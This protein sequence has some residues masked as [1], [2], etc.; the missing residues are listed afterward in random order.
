[1]KSGKL[2]NQIT[3]GDWNVTQV[4]G[5]DEKARTI[6]FL[7]VGKEAGNDPYFPMYYSVGFDGQNL[8]LL[9]PERADHE[10]TPSPDNRFFLDAFSTPIEPHQTVV[11]DARGE[12]VADVAREDITEAQS[13]RLDSAGADAGQGPRQSDRPL[14]LPLPPHQ[15][16]H[17]APLPHRQLRLSRPAD[18]LLRLRAFT[19]AHGDLQSLAEL[20]FIVVCIDGHGHA[21]PLQSL[22]RVL[23]ARPRRQHHPRP[24]RRHEAA[25]RT[26][27]VDRSRPRRHLGTLRRRQRHRRRHV[28]LP[29]LLQSR[30][31]RVRQ[32]RQPPLRRR[33]GREVDGSRSH[34]TRRQEQL[35]LAGQPERREVPQGPSAAR[36]RHRRRQRPAN[37]HPAS[38]STPSRR[39]TRTSTSSSSPT[40]TTATDPCPAT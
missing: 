21:L 36:A 8:A 38:S 27:P 20:G 6:F 25:R 40:P 24:G 16:L 12:I 3:S 34:R 22:P 26:L 1:M 2:K 5:V 33:L 15:L 23:R 17:R 30:H 19:A 28:P 18:R 11:R 37:Q 35:R 32:P 13:H 10:I 7:G 4:L 29:R 31:R 14:R 39:P 9:T